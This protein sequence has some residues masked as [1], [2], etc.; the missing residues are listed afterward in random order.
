[1]DNVKQVRSLI[2]IFLMRK[3]KIRICCGCKGGV[4]VGGGVGKRLKGGDGERSSAPLDVTWSPKF[5]LYFYFI[6][7]LSVSL[8]YV[9]KTGSPLHLHSGTRERRKRELKTSS[10]LSR[11]SFQGCVLFCSHPHHFC[12][13]P[14]SCFLFIWLLLAVMLSAKSLGILLL[15]EQNE[16]LVIG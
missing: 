16:R 4:E 2:S 5:L 11:A 6:I 13:Y 8:V 14:R 9:G 15:K 1:M 7:S 12:S 10:F 3:S